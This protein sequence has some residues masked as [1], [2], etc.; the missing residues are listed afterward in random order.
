MIKANFILLLT[1][2]LLNA[3][4]TDTGQAYSFESRCMGVDFRIVL[5]AHSAKQAEKAADRAF[6]RINQLNDMMS[7][8]K[9]DSELWKLS[10]S[11][12]KNTPVKV[13]DELWSVMKAS[14][15][16]HELS[17]G[18][19]DVSAGPFILL[20]RQARWTKSFPRQR[21]LE[22]AFAKSG[23]DK[24]EFDDK[25]Q[26]ILLKASAMRLDLGGIAKGYAADQ[27]LAV[28]KRNGIEYALV[29]GSGDM[30]MTDHPAGNWAVYISGS[31][32]K[33]EELLNLK[34]GAIATSGDTQQF[35]E[36][37]GKRY[38]HIIDPRSGLAL[39]NRLRV[40]VLAADCQTADS[41]ASTVS[42]LGPQKG[43]ELI[44]SLK[45]CEALIVHIDKGRKVYYK[46][47]GFPEF[48]K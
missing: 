43:L 32:E 6:E 10:E 4:S 13:S 22:R 48:I 46:S 12:G 5:Y 35:V 45:K 1:L 33:S 47:S 3:C 29:D 37:D 41:L 16:L 11:S 34:S 40:S 17:G 25:T 28:L 18:A 31:K 20:W 23:M 30:V 36:I 8:Y 21:S 39:E 26:R 14:Q 27:A 9:S 2:I 38:S 24:V 15:K 44:E 19:F 42:V 7:D